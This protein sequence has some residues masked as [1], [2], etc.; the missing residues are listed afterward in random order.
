MSWN[1]HSSMVSLWSF[2]FTHFAEIIIS[3]FWRDF[4]SLPYFIVASQKKKTDLSH[5]RHS[6]DCQ[7]PLSA[8]RRQAALYVGSSWTCFSKDW[9]SLERK[10]S[11][12]TKSLESWKRPFLFCRVQMC[13]I[14]RTRKEVIIILWPNR[15]HDGHDLIIIID[16]DSQRTNDRD[17][18]FL[19]SF[20]KSGS[21][22]S[23]IVH[24]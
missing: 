22:R 12:I 17:D 11:S 8:S 6:S 23:V 5:D 16:G 15:D 1:S 2:R 20:K 7:P 10:E 9:L 4:H 14:L 13:V 24:V 21:H 3:F 19:W 18:L